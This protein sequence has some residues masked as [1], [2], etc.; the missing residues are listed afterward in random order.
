MKNR[1]SPFGLTIFSLGVLLILKFIGEV[2]TSIDNIYSNMLM[3]FGIVSVF[4]FMNRRNK[5][6]LF[7]G[8]LAFM[9]GTTMFVFN[10]YDIMTTNKI[11]LPALLFIVS[12]PFLF[13]IID[14]GSQKIFLYI[15]LFLLI[16]AIGSLIFYSEFGWIRFS[17]SISRTVFN[18][19]PYIFIIVGI[20]VLTDRRK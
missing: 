15:S 13:L 1:I 2:D 12:M 10:H 7:I 6:G 20:G 19:W 9:V 3:F 14:D 8:V 17:A 4:V 18:L 5:G 16:S 11:I